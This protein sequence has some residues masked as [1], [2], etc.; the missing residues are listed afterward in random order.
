VPARNG[1]PR[2]WTAAEI[3]TAEAMRGKHTVREIA[4]ALGRPQPSVSN[5]LNRPER[6]AAAKARAS[7]SA[8]AKHEVPNGIHQR[9]GVIPAPEEPAVRKSAARETSPSG[10][11]GGLEP[12]LIIPDAHRPFHSKVWWD[13]LMQAG[14]FL[15]PKHLVIIGDFADF[16]EVSDHPKDPERKHRMPDELADVD[17]GL[18]DLDSLGAVS[19]IY[20]EG[21]HED[22]LRRH[23]QKDPA[24]A[25]VV[26]TRS[27]LKLD[28]RGWHFVPYKDHTSLGA[29]YFTHDVDASGRNAIY[30]ALETYQHTIITGHTHRLQYIVEGSA[31]GECKLSVSFGWGGDAEKVGY[32]N[33]ARAR[34][35]WALAF[36]IGYLEPSSGFVYLSPIPVVHGTCVVNGRLFRAA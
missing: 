24:L 2:P 34:K 6:M 12:I 18:N 11:S 26:N 25:G 13:L 7:Q 31:I 22:R 21:N 15:K 36:G 3:Q 28:E 9:L 5:L 8:K 16:Y 35:E 14:R 29:A 10:A 17:E 1:A 20:I 33:K 4:E 23:L 19:K 30:K 32:K 27:L